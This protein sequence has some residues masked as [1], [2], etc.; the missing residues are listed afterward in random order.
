MR[1]R[2]VDIDDR[3]EDLAD[4]MR[5]DPDFPSWYPEIFERRWRFAIGRIAASAR[6]MN[7][8]MLT[9]LTGTSLGRAIMTG[10]ATVG[11]PIGRIAAL[12]WLTLLFRPT[13]IVGLI[14]T[15]LSRYWSRSWREGY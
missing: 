8:D 2:F 13:S 3:M 7:R 9:R 4:R 12:A 5:A 15:G 10:A 1:T 6:P 14:R 11:G